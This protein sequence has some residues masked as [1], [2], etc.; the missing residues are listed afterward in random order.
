MQDCKEADPWDPV[1]P[2]YAKVTTSLFRGFSEAALDLVPLDSGA[3]I[4]DIACGP[5][6]LTFLASKRGIRV[7]AIDYSPSMIQQLRMRAEAEDADGLRIVE[8]DG[9][10]LP[11]ADDEFDAAFSLF[12]LMFFPDRLRG[13]QEMLRILK[14]EGT[15]CV[16]SWAPLIESPMLH[17]MW[18]A[19]QQ[20]D[21]DL[22]D[23]GSNHTPLEDPDQLK[24]EMTRAG[25][26]NVEVVK[27]ERSNSFAS[28][29]QFWD[30]MERGA[31]PVAQIKAQTAPATWLEQAERAIHFIEAESSPPPMN[32]SAKAWLGFGRKP[33]AVSC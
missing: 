18:R 12:G 11:F 3:H 6:T 10:D 26:Q 8:C 9:Q 5:G 1:A 13:F 7:S 17:L 19:L 23:P 4:A 15:G 28:A 25:F 27:I 29:A 33:S 16:S 24:E 20:I 2:G 21:T 22:P 32:L 30:S 14:P 31:L